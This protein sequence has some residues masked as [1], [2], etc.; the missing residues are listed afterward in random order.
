[1]LYSWAHESALF[2][3]YFPYL[4]WRNKKN[5]ERNVHALRVFDNM[6]DSTF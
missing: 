3:L 4:P 6:I 5:Q 2:L 1:M